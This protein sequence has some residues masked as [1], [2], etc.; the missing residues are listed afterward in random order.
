MRVSTIVRPIAKKAPGSQLNRAHATAGD[1]SP[2]FVFVSLTGAG[3]CIAQDLRVGGAGGA[4]AT[5]GCSGVAEAGWG[6]VNFASRSP[7]MSLRFATTR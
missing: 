1:R 7:L 4:A 5:S 2:A 6:R 3:M